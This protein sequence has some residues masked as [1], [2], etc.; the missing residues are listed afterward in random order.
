MKTENSAS[1]IICSIIFITFT[2]V[3][4]IFTFVSVSADSFG[5]VNYEN[6]YLVKIQGLRAH[7]FETHDAAHK[8]N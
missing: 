5:I 4:V 8:S 2:S 3:I 6:P 7:L 1:A